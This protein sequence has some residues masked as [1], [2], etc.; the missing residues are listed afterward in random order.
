MFLL[1]GSTVF[2]LTI[3]MTNNLFTRKHIKY[4]SGLCMYHIST[5]HGELIKNEKTNMFQPFTLINNADIFS[6][7]VTSEYLKEL[8]KLANDLMFQIIMQ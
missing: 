1:Y 7:V 3:T 2:V 8:E 4:H 6:L 5:F